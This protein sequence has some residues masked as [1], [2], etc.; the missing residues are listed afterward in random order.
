M[1]PPVGV[2]EL[3][4]Y[5]HTSLNSRIPFQA[6]P[7][8]R[9]E[10][11][12]CTR[13]VMREL[14]LDANDAHWSQHEGRLNR[15]NSK[16]IGKSDWAGRM[17]RSLLGDWLLL[18]DMFFTR[19]A[20][21]VLLPD[22]RWHST[23]PTKIISS[24]TTP[25]LIAAVNMAWE[26]LPALRKLDGLVSQ[27]RRRMD[28]HIYAGPRVG[29]LT[30]IAR[31]D[32]AIPDDAS[33]RELCRWMHRLAPYGIQLRLFAQ[34]VAPMA[35][36][37]AQPYPIGIL[38]SA[39]LNAFLNSTRRGQ[40]ALDTA[41]RSTL[42]LCCCIDLSY[43]AGGP[44]GRRAAVTAA[45]GNGFLCDE[46]DLWRHEAASAAS[47]AEH[48][49]AQT[50]RSQVR[51]GGRVGSGRATQ[52]ATDARG[53]VAAVE[54]RSLKLSAPSTNSCECIMYSEKKLNDLA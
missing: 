40:L 15:I 6:H 54:K 33:L 44:S 7:D 43:D 45:Q 28:A 24:S 51:H 39:A 19:I 3:P 52:A 49:R 30:L 27:L 23:P 53:L 34:N 42:L 4:R 25:F 8:A 50:S 9:G 29:V 26:V 22:M 5:N 13:S 14:Q 36:G 31:D 48:E 47:F 11:R 35:H 41:H 17:G 2:C 1:S 16:T 12:C 18:Q 10:L 32:V 20:H 21:A 38:E 46:S 37:V